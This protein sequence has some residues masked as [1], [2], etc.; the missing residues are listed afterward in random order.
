MLTVAQPTSWPR[1]WTTESDL[2]LQARLRQLPFYAPTGLGSVVDDVQKIAQKIPTLLPVIVSVIEDPAL[3]A[4]MQRIQTLQAIEARKPS[5]VA[6]TPTP[7]KPGVG[8]DRVLPLW[9][10]AIFIERHPAAQF[11][12]DHPVLVG[13][14]IALALGSV[15]YGLGRWTKRCRTS[16]LGRRSRRR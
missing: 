16:N 14:G 6:T 4:L 10:A 2:D 11:A 12:V 13:A 7:A 8:L 5:A 15:G 1:I 3:P 9:D